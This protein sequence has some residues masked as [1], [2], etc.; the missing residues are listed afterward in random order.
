MTEADTAG[1]WRGRKK[2]KGPDHDRGKKDGWRSA[3]VKLLIG[4]HVDM[5]MEKEQLSASS[6]LPEEKGKGCSRV[7]RI[8]EHD[9]RAEK[10]GRRARHSTKTAAKKTVDAKHW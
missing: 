3:L 5:I 8:G 1:E 6:V 10:E 9:M 7:A 4:I 2:S